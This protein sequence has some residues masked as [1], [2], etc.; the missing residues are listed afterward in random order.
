MVGI[1]ATADLFADGTYDR[2][3][4]MDKAAYLDFV[5]EIIR[6][7]DAQT[8]FEVLPSRWVVSSAPSAG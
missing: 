2:I 8:G 3:K 4:L 5:I 7:S 1:G 6:R